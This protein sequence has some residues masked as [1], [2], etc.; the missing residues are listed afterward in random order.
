[1]LAEAPHATTVAGDKLFDVGR[2]V[3]PTRQLGI[4]RATP[5]VNANGN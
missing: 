5:S 1:M 4:I 3:A 2:F